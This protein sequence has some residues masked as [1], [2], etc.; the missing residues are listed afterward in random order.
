MSYNPNQTFEAHFS[1]R[2]DSLKQYYPRGPAAP[3]PTPNPKNTVSSFPIGSDGDAGNQFINNKNSI[4]PKRGFASVKE[5][6]LTS[7]MWS[8]RWLM[9]RSEILTFHK[10]E[11]KKE[12]IV[13]YISTRS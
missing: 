10:N 12:I 7:F 9:L 3:T 1:P 5:D 4:A 8:K 6:G 13:E 11:V 2:K